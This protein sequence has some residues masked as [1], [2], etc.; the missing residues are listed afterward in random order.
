MTRARIQGVFAESLLLGSL[1]FGCGGDAMDV[2]S[3]GNSGAG[4]SAGNSGA[5][6]SAG[7]SG[8]GNSA[9]GS[10]ASGGDVSATGGSGPV[11]GQAGSA[12]EPPVDPLQLPEG[13][14]WI[15][16]PNTALSP[17]CACN[18]GFDEVCAN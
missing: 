11:T 14:G 2:P 6:N 12:G 9:A 13:T 18:D 4:N 3:A 16:L 10:N 1:A 7:N 15:E 17:V 5:G 8:A